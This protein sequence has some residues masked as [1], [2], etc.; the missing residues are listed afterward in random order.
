MAAITGPSGSGKS[1]LLHLV[2][3]IDR[4]TR[5]SVWIGDQETSRLSDHQLTILRKQ[6]IG[7][8]FQFFHLIPTLTVVENVAFPLRLLGVPGPET[9]DRVAEILERVGLS[10]R[11]NHLPCQLSGGELQRVA[12]GPRERNDPARFEVYPFLLRKGRRRPRLQVRRLLACKGGPTG[13]AP[14]WSPVIGGSFLLSRLSHRI[15]LMKTTRLISIIILL[16]L[17]LSAAEVEL[18]EGVAGQFADL[19]LA[20]VAQE[21]PNKIAH[22]MHSDADALA[23]RELTPVFYGCYDWHSAV[24]GHW[25]LVRLARLQP[26]AAFRSRALAAVE[27]NLT[28]EG[29]AQEVAYLEGEGRASF[30]RPYGL[31]WLLQLGTELR[32]WQDPR[33]EA[34][35]KTLAPLEQAAANRLKEW[36]PKLAYPIR[37]GEHSQTAFAFGLILDWARESGD[38]ELETM[39]GSAIEGFYLEDRDCP[40]EYEPSGQD[41]LSPCIAEADL[42][43]RVLPPVEYA[44]WLGGFLPGIPR[45]GSSAWLPLGIVTDRSDG[46]LAHLDGL[47][48]SRAWMLDGMAS[49]LPEGDPRAG[50]LLAAA[51]AHAESG[52]ASVTGEHYEGGHWLGSFA[53]YLVTK[54][55]IDRP[56]RPRG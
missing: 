44:A 36:L 35:A 27:A 24:H 29:V 42:V 9:R 39:L 4:P 52:L 26:E 41:F 10:N 32:Q 23:P 43:R 5:G 6:S 8:I 12:I 1:T 30:E 49:G 2:G 17:P 34:M 15:C 37:V 3:A 20:C 50:S 7:F 14:S 33:A 18:S 19:A 45:D 56:A 16:A 48:I 53:T 28:S 13:R 31:A 25:L 11:E 51:A 55:G 46:K 22:V 54:R 47:N 40:L 38:D 21:Y